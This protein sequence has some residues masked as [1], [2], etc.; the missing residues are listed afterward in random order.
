VTLCD[1][2][3]L[4]ALVDASLG[5]EHTRCAQAADHL[6]VPFIVTWPVI[7]EALYFAGKSGGWP[8]QEFV[9][10]LLNDQRLFKV[11]VSSPDEVVRIQE[12]MEKYEDLPMDLADATLVAAAEVTGIRRV[13]TLD[14]DFRIYR[15]RDGG[16]FEVFPE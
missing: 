11:H 5:D 2:G 14:S 8:M 9:W 10:G 1:T 3:P 6:A 12:M 16:T 13:F 4:L 7:T 15:T